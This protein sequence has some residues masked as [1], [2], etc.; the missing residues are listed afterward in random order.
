VKLQLQLILRICCTLISVSSVFP[1]SGDTGTGKSELLG[2][3]CTVVNSNCDIMPDLLF[4]VQQALIS[5]MLPWQ[6]HAAFAR[7]FG[8]EEATG[9]RISFLRGVSDPL[10]LFQLVEQ[11]VEWA[12]APDSLGSVRV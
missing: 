9:R 2:L 6:S 10:Q 4:E 11:H 7:M 8:T 1:R 3:Y 12:N 5:A